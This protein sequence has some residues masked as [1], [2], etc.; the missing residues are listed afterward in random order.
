M[1]GCC[2]RFTPGCRRDPPSSWSRAASMWCHCCSG[3]P[4][5]WSGRCCRGVISKRD[6]LMRG[7]SMITRRWTFAGLF[8]LLAAGPGFGQDKPAAKLKVLATFSI[9]G[10]LVGNVGGERVEVTTLVGP[11]SDAHV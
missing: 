9:L 7:G 5:A 6:L 8:V 1:P 10:D 2:C 3:R 11:N 4:A